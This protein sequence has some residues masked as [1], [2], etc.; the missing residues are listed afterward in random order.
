MRIRTVDIDVEPELGF[1]YERALPL[2]GFVLTGLGRDYDPTPDGRRMLMVFHADD[3]DEADVGPQRIR[4]I[5][6]WTEELKRLVP[7]EN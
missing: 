5:L 1:S 3:L 4:I 6:S 2:D 7:T